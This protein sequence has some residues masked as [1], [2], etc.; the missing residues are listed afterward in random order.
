MSDN[1]GDINNVDR[2]DIMKAFFSQHKAISK[3]ILAANKVST[4]NVN[5]RDENFGLAAGGN[6]R[7]GG[8]RFGMR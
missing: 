3:K 7:L 2:E 4:I 5:N 8:K 6:R 1:N